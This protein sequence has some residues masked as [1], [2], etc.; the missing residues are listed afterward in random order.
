MMLQDATFSK[1]SLRVS[2]PKYVHLHY[3]MQIGC[4]CSEITVTEV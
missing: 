4:M 2:T 3:S 1:T